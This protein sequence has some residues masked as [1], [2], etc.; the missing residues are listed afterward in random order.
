M[1]KSNR[2]SLLF[3]FYLFFLIF[4]IPLKAQ[5]QF[6]FAIVPLHS[7]THLMENWGPILREI[8]LETGYKFEIKLYKS[9]QEFE[10]DLLSEAFDFAYVNPFQAVI[11]YKKFKYQPILRNSDP[12]FGVVGV[13][14]DSPIKDILQLEEKT[15]AFASPQCPIYK[16]N[17][18][19]HNWR[20]NVSINLLRIKDVYPHDFSV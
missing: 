11:A 7:P 4:P 6:S 18:I 3:L 12:L 13:R 8:S 17:Y 20:N 2:K 5:E 1:S 14:K 15:I 16:I 10:K 19:F 9:L